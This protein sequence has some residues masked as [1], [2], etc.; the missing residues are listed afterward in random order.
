MTHE[1]ITQ[2]Y[3]TVDIYYEIMSDI[4]ECCEGCDCIDKCNKE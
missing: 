2:E 1:E 3:Q 4:E